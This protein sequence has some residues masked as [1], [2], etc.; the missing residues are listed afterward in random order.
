M[1]RSRRMLVAGLLVMALALVSTASAGDYA[2][3]VLADSPLGWWRLDETSGATAANQVAGSPDGTY[4]NFVAGDYGVLGFQADGTVAANFDG[5]NNYVAIPNSVVSGIGTGAFTIEM[6]YRDEKASRGDPFGLK[7]AGGDLG[8]IHEGNNNPWLYWNSTAIAQNGAITENAWH[9]VAFTRDGASSMTMYVDGA[10][11]NTGSSGNNISSIAADIWIGSNRS[12][13]TPQSAFDGQIADVAVYGSDIGATRVQDH[14]DAHKPTI[15]NQLPPYE[16]LPPHMGALAYW[17]LN[18][19]AGPTA[20]DQIGALD[21]TYNGFAP[22]D[23]NQPGPLL[24]WP[25]AAP[26]FHSGNQNVT[27]NGDPLAS[28]I[29]AG[30]F[31]LS[32]WFLKETGGR[33]DMFSWKNNAGSDDLGIIVQDDG[34]VDVWLVINSSGG[35]ALDST[36]PVTL[37]EWHH[38][39]LVRWNGQLLSYIDAELNALGASSADLSQIDLGTLI[40]IGSNHT[41]GT[42]TILFDGQ[43]SEV[44]LFG[45]ALTWQQVSDLYQGRFL[46]APEPGTM[47]LFGVGIAALARRRRRR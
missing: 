18:E 4:T 40:R 12:G 32:M 16:A 3:E 17:R 13:T 9:H 8:L 33:Q 23:F 28:A 7:G 19:P 37:N 45:S 21:G 20:A 42:P 26:D 15:P 22:A 35:M 5:S 39:A 14:Y 25:S 38:L 41:G 10:V 31:A 2:A 43:I 27:V 30:D 36:T 47:A 29:G 34:T 11:Y 46:S 44:A 24:N 6:W 1:Q